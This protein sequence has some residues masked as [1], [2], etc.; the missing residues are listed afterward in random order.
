LVL[1]AVIPQMMIGKKFSGPVLNPV[2]S[3]LGLYFG[4][5]GKAYLYNP[6][7][8]LVYVVSPFIGTFLAAVIINRVPFL[9]TR[10]ETRAPKPEKDGLEKEKEKDKDQ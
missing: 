1:V 6:F 8:W 4:S 3:V 5:S 7:W 9:K 10:V 2:L